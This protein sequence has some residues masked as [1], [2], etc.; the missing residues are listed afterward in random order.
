MGTP[1]TD[2]A[3][4]S[5]GVKVEITSESPDLEVLGIT[6]FSGPEGSASV[7]DTTSLKDTAKRKKM[8]LP[9][10][11]SFG[12]ELNYLPK[13][14]GQAALQTARKNRTKLDFKVTFTDESPETTA[15]FSA[16]VTDF[17]VKGGVD[18]KIPATVKL[19]I[20]GAVIWA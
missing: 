20:D 5:E 4:L 14:P 2:E 16:Y 9:D 12:L 3:M 13:D 17:A 11:G 7:I 19:E 18:E 10:E 6:N 15:S 1:G 8:G